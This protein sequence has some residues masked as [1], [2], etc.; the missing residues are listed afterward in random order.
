MTSPVPAQDTRQTTSS[1]AISVRVDR[2]LVISRVGFSCASIMRLASARERRNLVAAAIETGLTHFDVARLHGLG[3]A[4]SELGRAL[5][6]HRAEVTVATKFGI[7]AVGALRRLRRL[8]AP[9]R[10]V[11][12]RSPGIRAAVRQRREAFAT[13]R[14]YDADRARRS[15]DTSLRELSLDHVDILFLHDPRPHDEIDSA[16]L[17]SFLEGAQAAGKIRAW[18]MSFDDDTGLEVLSRLRDP[19]IVQLRHHALIDTR[20]RPRS[21]AFGSLSAQPD[22]SRWLSEQ[23]RVRRRWTEAI[24]ADPLERDRLSALLLSNTLEHDGVMACLYAT[25]KVAGLALPASLLRSPVPAEQVQAF[26]RC[27]GDDRDSILNLAAQ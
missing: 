24:G 5:S 7:D 18:G 23:P 2:D 20:P 14:V 12:A 19:G 11:L 17:M 6:G 27:L 10:L 8:Q 9:A 21:I 13:P 22:I 3:A 1:G 15:L 25:T 4:E 16:A 26:A